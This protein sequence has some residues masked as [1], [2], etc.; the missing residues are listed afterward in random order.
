MQLFQ[1][2]NE[3]ATISRARE[4]IAQLDQNEIGCHLPAAKGSAE[5]L[6]LLVPDIPAIDQGDVKGRIDKT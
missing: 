1:Q 6:S 3:Y 2:L 4:P 5:F